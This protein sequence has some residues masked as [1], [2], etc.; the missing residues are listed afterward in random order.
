MYMCTIVIVLH[1]NIRYIAKNVKQYYI[2]YNLF[3]KLVA[4]N[5]LNVLVY[6]YWKQFVFLKL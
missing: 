1:Q 4:K 2:N 3:F 5:S 6:F